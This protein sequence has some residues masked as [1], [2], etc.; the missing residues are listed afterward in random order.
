VTDLQLVREAL[1]ALGK[2]WGPLNEARYVTT[3]R[4]ATDRLEAR[5]AEVE[6]ERD[7]ALETAADFNGMRVRAEKERDEALRLLREGR[8]E[9]LLRL[10][11][12]NRAEA[13]EA[14]LALLKGALRDIK[15]WGHSWDSAVADAA[16][17]ATESQEHTNARFTGSWG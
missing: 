12:E 15:R 17:A 10:L 6:R 9:A 7:E 3:A 2:R 16:L 14:R 5:L 1:D 4:E 11:R 8:D 13:A